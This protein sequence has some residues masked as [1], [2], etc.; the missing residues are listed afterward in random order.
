ML[1]IISVQYFSTI[2]DKISLSHWFISS[3]LRISFTLAKCLWLLDHLI[4][5]PRSYHW[6]FYFCCDACYLTRM[7][8]VLLQINKIVYT[9]RNVFLKTFVKLFILYC[10]QNLT[11]YMTNYRTCQEEENSLQDLLSKSKEESWALY[12]KPEW[13]SKALQ[14]RLRW[15]S[16]CVNSRD[17]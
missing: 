2:S 5:T 14:E 8:I 4:P 17:P 9:K 15:T 16:L 13:W 1:L 12:G 10:L 7:F 3:F 11:P 6:I